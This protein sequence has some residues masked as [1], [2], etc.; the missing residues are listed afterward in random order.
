M[1]SRPAFPPCCHPGEL[2]S[3]ALACSPSVADRKEWGQFFCS[4]TCGSSSPELTTP[5]PALMFLHRWHTGPALWITALGEAQGQLFECPPQVGSP[6]CCR[7]QAVGGG[8]HISFTFA[9][10][11]HVRV[12]AG[13][14]LTG[15]L[16]CVSLPHTTGF[17]LLFCPG[18]VQGLLSP[19]RGSVN[20]PIFMVS[21]PALPQPQ[22]AEGAGGGH[23]SL[24]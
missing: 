11:W 17:S 24:W 15:L 18:E 14:I 10:P 1:V 22:I 13:L 21:G 20:F 4:H 3:T 7:R 6:E 16:T 19:V 12:G 2:S 23:V 9:I 5:G 8:G